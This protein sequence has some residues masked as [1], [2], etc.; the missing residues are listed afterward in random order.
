MLKASPGGVGKQSQRGASAPKSGSP[1][2]FSASSIL[3]TI[4]IGLQLQVGIAFKLW[5]GS[6]D[7]TLECVRNRTHTDAMQIFANVG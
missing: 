4:W 1:S 3:L 7:V 6:D 2:Q 5:V